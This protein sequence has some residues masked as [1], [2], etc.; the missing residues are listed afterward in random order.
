ME[1]EE[2][3]TGTCKRVALETHVRPERAFPPW[4][5]VCRSISVEIVDSIKRKEKWKA[6]KSAK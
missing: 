5:D 2:D 3:V 1:E 6:V 4:R